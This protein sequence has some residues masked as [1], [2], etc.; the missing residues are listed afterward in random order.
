M[1][2]IIRLRATASTDD[3]N[4]VDALG[5]LPAYGLSPFL[6]S[7]AAVAFDFDLGRPGVPRFLLRASGTEGDGRDAARAALAGAWILGECAPAWLR[8]TG[9]EDLLRVAVSARTLAGLPYADE[10]V[11][12]GA[13]VVLT[14]EQYGIRPAGR[15]RAEEL[16]PLWEPDQT[17]YVCGSASFA[18]SATQLL[19]AS[20]RPAASIRVERFGPSGGTA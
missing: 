11:A 3:A 9:R 5:V 19:V 7:V 4:E 20:G 8:A 2:E 10:L 18:E 6:V 15:L 13:L 12:A 17:V 1:G 14:R 16:L